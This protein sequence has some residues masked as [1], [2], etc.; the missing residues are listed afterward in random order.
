M[1]ELEILSDKQILI[2]ILNPNF[3]LSMFLAQA[4]ACNAENFHAMGF[5]VTSRIC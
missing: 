5:M 3:A 4:R 2:A 1:D